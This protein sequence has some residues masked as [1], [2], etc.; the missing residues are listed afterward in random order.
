MLNFNEFIKESN[1]QNLF[2]ILNMEKIKYLFENE[3]LT[4]YQAGNG[5]V[6]FTRDKM[7]N[8]YLG[9]NGAFIKLEIDANKLNTKYRINPFS[10]KSMNGQRFDEREERVRGEIK[11]V[12]KYVNKIIIIKSNIESLRKNFRD[13]IP[14]DYFT[15][16]GIHSEFKNIPTMIKYIVD[17]S[18][19]E[20]YVQD[21]SVIRKDDEYLNSLINYELHD[22]T[23]KYDV[24]YRGNFK[25]PKL[26]FGRKDT[27]IDSDGNR[28]EDFV[29]GEEYP[30]S[31]N[32]KSKENLNINEYPEFKEIEGNE[33]KAYVV[34][35]REISNGNYYLED[36]RPPSWGLDKF[37]ESNE[38]INE[39]VSNDNMTKFHIKKMVRSIQS[40][41]KTK[42]K[43]D[44]LSKSFFNGILRYT[45]RW[46]VDHVIF[47][48]VLKSYQSS[49]INKGILISYRKG[50]L[51][52]FDFSDDDSF[53]LINPRPS[54]CREFNIF[55]KDLFTR[56]VKPPRYIYHV[57]KSSNVENIL[58]NGL[59]LKSREEGNFSK[60]LDLHY[61]PS[62]FA[63]KD[64]D[65]WHVEDSVTLEIDTK[66]LDNKWW[67]DLN[68]FND[69]L[70]ENDT[71]MM[72]FKSISPNHIKLIDPN[73]GI[74]D[75]RL[76]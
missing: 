15:T 69:K 39:L 34:K 8:G 73:E 54:K 52:E 37:L 4:P 11:D 36:I 31:L 32:L 59:E 53:D 26:R 35:F 14:S 22:V 47:E 12:F 28:Y 30:P 20:V 21:G 6:S 5:Y 33:C 43:N 13:I 2:H 27:L 25:H 74:D 50:E 7:M 23:F 19:V 42:I 29:I 41:S 9:S 63:S 10:Y 45:F 58:K 1:Y 3:S 56:R 51:T 17:N 72:T 70:P 57:T 46:I 65:E 76:K 67:Q 55:V 66:G 18:P 68:L 75:I 60:E 48:K 49:L 62:I 61:P 44:Q 38:K 40:K 71:Y 16:A 24:W 64:E